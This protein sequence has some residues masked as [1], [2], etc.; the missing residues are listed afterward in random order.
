MLSSVV[1][2]LVSLA[3]L[4]DSALAQQLANGNYLQ[5]GTISSTFRWQASG[6]LSKGRC[7]ISVRASIQ[8]CYISHLDA[9]GNLQETTQ[10]QYL[11]AI[12]ASSAGTADGAKASGAFGVASVGSRTSAARTAEQRALLDDEDL[13]A[14]FEAFPEQEQYRYEALTRTSTFGSFK[15]KRQVATCD[16]D[17]NS[18][19][20][21]T[22]AT[23]TVT[24]TRTLQNGSTRTVTS[25]TAVPT[26]TEVVSSRQRNEF[27]SWPGAVAGTTWKYTWKSYQ[28]RGVSTNFNFFHAWQILRRDGCGGP[29]VTLDYLDGQVVVQ[30]LI[31][32]CKQCAGFNKN[33]AN[34]WL[35]WTISHDLTVTYGLNGSISYKA[36]VGN[37]LRVPG[38]SY[39]STVR[40]MGSSASIKFGN[41]RKFVEGQTAA[42]AYV[43][44]FTQTQIS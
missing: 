35:G 43:G 38:I 6:V 4:V 22:T 26:T 23:V 44:D 5:T 8:D 19:S 20:T 1:G 42:T 7:P 12:S 40:D 36:F 14:Y 9:T 13:D 29:V 34:Y 41:Y 30:D 17:S 27:L 18:T 31:V 21:S 16:S 3:L 10:A 15:A 39:T 25:T 24:S 28:A 32:G 11:A 2:A 37:N 33:F